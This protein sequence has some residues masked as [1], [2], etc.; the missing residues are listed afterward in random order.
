MRSNQSTLQTLCFEEFV[1]Q[2]FLLE[3]ECKLLQNSEHKIQK[4]NEM[5]LLL[6]NI[7]RFANRHLFDLKNTEKWDDF[8][9]EI[10]MKN[11]SGT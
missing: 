1:S 11:D 8:S 9:M 5:Q 2:D 10:L 3:K 7:E 4:F 6:Q